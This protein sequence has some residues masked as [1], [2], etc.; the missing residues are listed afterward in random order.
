MIHSIFT[1]NLISGS[2]NKYLFILNALFTYQIVYNCII[3]LF[4][5]KLKSF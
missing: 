5:F 4:F 1:V 3:I 2:E